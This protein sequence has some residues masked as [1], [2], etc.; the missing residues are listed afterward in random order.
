MTTIA[1]APHFLFLFERLREPDRLAEILPLICLIEGSFHMPVVFV[2]GRDLQSCPYHVPYEL[3][4][5][6]RSDMWEGYIPP[7]D[8]CF[9]HGLF[10]QF[11]S[12]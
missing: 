2:N 9:R 3:V 5:M 8:L 4:Y 7:A 12:G 1:E 6:A 11:I 10:I